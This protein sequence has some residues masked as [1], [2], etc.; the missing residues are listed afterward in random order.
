MYHERGGAAITAPPPFCISA[1]NDG[2]DFHV[3]S[4]AF[5][6]TDVVE[7]GACWDFRT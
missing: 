3:M 7:V 2:V 5:A 1:N 4:F 6:Q